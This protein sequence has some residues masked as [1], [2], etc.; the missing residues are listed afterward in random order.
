MEI[1]AVCSQIH[2]EHINTV[3]GQ[4]VG[5]VSVKPGGTYSDRWTIVKECATCS[6]DAL[7]ESC[8]MQFLISATTDSPALV[9][10]E[11]FTSFQDPPLHLLP[12]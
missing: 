7:V 10:N 9:C 8:I 12:F 1:I 2:T 6:L 3:C 11:L 4:N 5:F